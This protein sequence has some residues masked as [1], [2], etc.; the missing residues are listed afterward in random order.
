MEKRWCG[1]TVCPV[2]GRGIYVY[3]VCGRGF[4][5]CKAY[6]RESADKILCIPVH[7]VIIGAVDGR[8][9]YARLVDRNLN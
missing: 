3:K 9:V 4:C 7:S 1:Y 8:F 6:G 5:V 2:V